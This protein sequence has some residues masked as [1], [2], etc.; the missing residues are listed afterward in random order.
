VQA[1]CILSI[2]LVRR[3]YGKARTLFFDT[4]R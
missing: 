1:C 4:Y 2:C 3:T